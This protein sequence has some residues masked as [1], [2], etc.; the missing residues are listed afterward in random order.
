MVS[1]YLLLYIGIGIIC[2]LCFDVLYD[3]M[4]MEQASMF[5]RLFWFVAWPFFLI[6]FLYGMYKDDDE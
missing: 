2:G 1:S 4:D 5:E 3:R 6:M